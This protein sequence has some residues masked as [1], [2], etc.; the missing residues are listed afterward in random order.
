MAKSNFEDLFAINESISGFDDETLYP[1]N[2]EPPIIKPFDPKEVDIVAKTMVIS[3]IIEQLRDGE[4]ILNPE[5][6]RKAN[7]WNEKDQ[8]RLI[9]SI[10]IRIPLP[11][12][13]FDTTEDEKLIVVDGLQRLTA[14][15][16]FAV[17]EPNNK[18]KLRLKD[19]EYINEYNGYT[20]EE[21]PVNIQRRIRQTEIIAYVIRKGTPDNVRNSIFTRINT[22]GLRLEP[23]EIRNAVYRGVA[24]TLLKELAESPA[25]K[26]ATKNR[27]K[28]DRM[29]DRELI[30]RFLA[31][32]ILGTEKYNGNLESYL[33]QV[34]S[35]IKTFDANQIN[36]V[37]TA[38]TKSMEVAA[39]LFGDKAFRRLNSNG[40]YG[41]INKP[42]FECVS[43]SLSELSEERCIFLVRRKED[44]I[45][46]YEALFFNKE[47][48]Q[49]ISNAT[50]KLENVKRR[51]AMFKEILD[52]VI[53]NA[54]LP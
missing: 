46:C 32:Y 38:F 33:N 31:F 7:L 35:E 26:E 10:I 29:E 4:I 37:K 2:S 30:N 28:C 27:I 53:G 40:K 6:Q 21:L 16:R 20:F 9:E 43:V 11:S 14:I 22:A 23:A 47:F 49:I 5:Y 3:N 48:T 34:L 1:E 17:L 41:K 18:D 25:F 36:D 44:F 39:Q 13:Y 19:L 12:F 8:S 54:T 52:E 51:F 24:S 45:L 50:A 15:R 42:L